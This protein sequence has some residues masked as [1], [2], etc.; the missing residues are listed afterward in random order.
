M[1]EIV[2]IFGEAST[3]DL[4]NGIRIKPR[5]EK[6]SLVGMYF[7][8]EEEKT[9]Q[10]SYKTTIEELKSKTSDSLSND[11]L[12]DKFKKEIIYLKNNINNISD[13]NISK[14]LTDVI[15]RLGTQLYD[16]AATKEKIHNFES[17]FWFKRLR[18]LIH[19]DQAK[20]RK[21]FMR[22]ATYWY[23]LIELE[24]Y[25]EEEVVQVLASNKS[26][27]KEIVEKW[28]VKHF[29]DF[30]EKVH[31]I[32]STKQIEH[33]INIIKNSSATNEVKEELINKLLTSNIL[34]TWNN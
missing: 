8:I 29:S 20:T 27:M 25:S 14:E 10:T 7:Y 11:D 5:Y 16:N 9:I 1:N 15:A 28:N 26:K 12:L 30:I 18:D 24:G 3:K 13:V 21:Q 34:D 4:I 23:V 17:D 6:S 33:F 22:L 31:Y 2:N 19:N 32:A